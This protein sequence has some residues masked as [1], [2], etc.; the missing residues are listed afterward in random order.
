M[1]KQPCFRV[2]SLCEQ[3]V[4]LDPMA[5]A[6]GLRGILQPHGR[7][8]LELLFE[9]NTDCPFSIHLVTEQCD[10]LV[11]ETDQGAGWLPLAYA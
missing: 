6:R 10:R 11:P 1:V 8:A 9:D 7:D 2:V 5:K 3:T 4:P